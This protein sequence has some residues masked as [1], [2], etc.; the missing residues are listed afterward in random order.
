MSIV[1]Y[2]VAALLL[3]GCSAAQVGQDVSCS[4]DA[5]LW[6]AQKLA[7]TCQGRV[8]S[9]CPESDSIGDEYERK[10]ELECSQQ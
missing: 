9:E 8:L 6:F 5:D 2:L 7:M 10:A 4:P 1:K 3:V